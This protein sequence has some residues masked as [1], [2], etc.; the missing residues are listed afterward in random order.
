M[1]SSPEALVQYWGCL[2]FEK[3]GQTLSRTH[4]HRLT[5]SSCLIRGGLLTFTP[6]HLCFLSPSS[7]SLPFSLRLR[8]LGEHS[9]AG[10]GSGCQHTDSLSQEYAAVSWRLNTF[11]RPSGAAVKPGLPGPALL[12]THCRMWNRAFRKEVI[13]Y[14]CLCVPLTAGTPRMA[15]LA[16]PLGSHVSDPD[17]EEMIHV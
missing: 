3:A 11:T 15:L 8:E 17:Q 9:V 2:L 5:G 12:T 16:L 13:S 14:M 10:P 1:A 7:V 4:V 6:Q